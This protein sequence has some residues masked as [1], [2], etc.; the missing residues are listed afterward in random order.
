MTYETLICD[1]KG[2]IAV[3]TLNRP[4]RMNAL[5]EQLV[6]ELG[7]V[8]TEIEEDEQVKVVIL[9][10]HEKF[11]CAGADIREEV[12]V[13]FLKNV[14]AVFHKIESCEK[15]SIAAVSGIAYGGGCELSLVCDLRIASETAK[16]AV[17]E[18]KIGAIPAGGGTQRLP[19]L[20]GVTRA[21]ELLFSGNPID[22]HEAYRIGLV[23]RVVP[24]EGLVE[25]AKKMAQLL[26]DRPP[27]ALTMA[28]LAVNTSMNTNLEAGLDYEAHCAAIIFTTEDIKEGMAAFREKRKPV[29]KGR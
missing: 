9:T 8:M 25:E 23:N 29:W 5:D 7:Q 24:T 1:K 4:Q 17:P 6:R 28:K 26:L 14:R 11:F 12:P 15:P 22:A 18:I 3:I 21:K 20:I 13:N 16:F 27:V 2:G 10:G 19:R